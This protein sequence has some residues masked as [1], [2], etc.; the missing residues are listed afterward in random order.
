MMK[1]KNSPLLRLFKLKINLADRERFEKAGM[2]N[3]TT[4]IQ[5]EKGTLAMYSAHL[6]EAG[7]E[8]MVI[9]SYQDEVHYQKHANSAQFKMFSNIASQAVIEKSMINLSPELLLEKTT[10]LHELMPVRVILKVTSIEIESN[11]VKEFRE[12]SL[13]AMKRSFENEAGLLV[14]YIAS[15]D[16][17]LNQWVFVEIYRSDEDYQA[18]LQTMNFKKY[19][20]DTEKMVLN[21]RIE[22]PI[23]DVLVNQGG[24]FFEK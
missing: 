7:T 14:T 10:A 17:N 6:D 8:N 16:G 23:S 18:H 13:S 11:K 12:A 4:S 3:L 19:A 2:V 22:T 1:L 24:L 15:V 21:Q 20:T 9:E 5:Q